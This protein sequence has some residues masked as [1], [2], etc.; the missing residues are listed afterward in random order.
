MS[1]R[2]DR[3]LCIL[4]IPPAGARERPEF[5]ISFSSEGVAAL[6]EELGRSLK[7]TFQELLLVL[8]VLLLFLVGVDLLNSLGAQFANGVCDRRLSLLFQ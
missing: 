7:E 8:A 6:G 4:G 1:A 3:T 2:G 5:L